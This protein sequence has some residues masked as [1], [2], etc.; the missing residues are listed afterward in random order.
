MNARERATRLATEKTRL[1]ELEDRATL[2]LLLPELT[3]RVE[4]KVVTFSPKPELPRNVQE[5]ALLLL[6]Y[7][8]INL[9]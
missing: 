9:N 5:E 8:R 4:V 7:I 2:T 3:K 1:K 6:R